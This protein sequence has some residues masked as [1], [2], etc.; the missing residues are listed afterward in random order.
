MSVSRTTGPA[1]LAAVIATGLLLGGCDDGRRADERG[2]AA[3]PQAESPDTQPDGPSASGTDLSSGFTADWAAFHRGGPLHG[4]ADPI[5]PPPMKVRWTYRVGDRAGVVNSA[6]IVDRTVYV[7]DDASTVHAI[8][9]DD[10]QSRWK[11]AFEDGFETAPLVADGKVMLGDAAGVFRC[12]SA[13]KGEELWKYDSEGKICSSANRLPDG[14]IVFANDN[15]RVVCLDPADGRKVWTRDVER[16]NGA[17]VVDGQTIWIASCDGKL[18]ALDATD[19]HSLLEVEI[20]SETGAAPLAADGAV[21]VGQNE[22]KVLCADATTGEVRWTYDQV[23]DGAMI[24]SSAA[25]ADGVVVFGARDNQ[26]HAINV[27]DGTRRWVFP[28][29]G[30]VDS[31]P[32]ISGGRVYVGSKDGKLYVLNLADG[33]PL[34]QFTA[35]REITAGPAIGRGVVVVGDSAGNVYCFAP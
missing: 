17:P 13:D 24:Y 5:A 23:A 6:V 2:D 8:N 30:E 32:A 28:T 31:S 9:L 20:G 26:V 21:M 16:T 3:Q 35:G 12:L 29:Q 22:G 33:K 1:V 18:H 27:G 11:R 25:F 10:G 7:A 15:G 14:R 34:W 4:A 19:G